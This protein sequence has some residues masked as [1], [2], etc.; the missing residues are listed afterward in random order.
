MNLKQKIHLA[1]L[2][3]I[4]NKLSNQNNTIK[5]LEFSVANETKSTAGDKYETSLAMLQ[6]EI[7]NEA[8]KKEVLNELR[9]N[10]NT[11]DP[12]I[13]YTTVKKGSLVKCG[14]YYFYISAAIGKLNIDSIEVMAIS[15]IAPLA[16]LLINLSIG[17]QVQYN[18]QTFIIDT[19]L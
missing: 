18:N 11:L 8:K 15:P 3:L 19:I 9:L 7:V 14:K 13:N 12:S 5:D 4:K 1:F 17:E 16:K 2:E 10:L 6:I